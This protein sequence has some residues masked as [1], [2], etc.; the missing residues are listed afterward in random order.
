MR[1]ATS[2]AYEHRWRMLAVLSLSLLL[3]G[4]DNTVLNV[5]LPTLQ[6]HFD[7]SG[8][9]L[10]WI[11]DGYL[12]A[13]AVPPTVGPALARRIV[14]FNED[15]SGIV[16]RIEQAGFAAAVEKHRYFQWYSQP[17][18]D[19]GDGLIGRRDVAAR[20]PARIASGPFTGAHYGAIASETA[21]DLPGLIAAYLEA[22][23]AVMQL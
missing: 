2:T 3:T 12:L 8:S 20:M 10:Q 13:F 18:R 19:R 5:A 15:R 4:L 14:A 22:Y 16:Q 6:T 21:R 9:T 23:H 17:D 1:T 11:V 7:A